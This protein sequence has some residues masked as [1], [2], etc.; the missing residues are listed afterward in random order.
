MHTASNTLSLRFA[1][2]DAIQGIFLSDVAMRSGTIC[3]SDTHRNGS[4]LLLYK[5]NMV[6]LFKHL[7]EITVKLSQALRLFNL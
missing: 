6:K 1:C 2:L 5:E 7:S 4:V 3:N